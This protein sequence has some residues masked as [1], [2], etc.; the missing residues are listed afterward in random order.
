M[1]FNTKAAASTK[2]RDL[3]I[4]Q[5]K[6]RIKSGS[7]AVWMYDDDQVP[8]RRCKRSV[9]SSVPRVSTS[10]ACGAMTNACRC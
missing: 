10:P 1:Y 6:H 8:G 2:G 7:G 4:H 3:G 5:C 9:K